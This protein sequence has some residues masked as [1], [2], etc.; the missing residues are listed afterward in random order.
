VNKCLFEAA[1][2]LVARGFAIYPAQAG[3]QKRLRGY[4]SD[5]LI[6]SAEHAERI[7]K[8]YPDANIGFVPGRS[9]MAVLDADMRNGGL[10]TH[11]NICSEIGEA[12]M[13]GAPVGLTP[14]GGFHLYFRYS[15]GPLP[16]NGLGPGIDI[17]SGNAGAIIPPSQRQDGSYRWVWDRFPNPWDPPP[18]PEALANRLKSVKTASSI[19]TRNPTIPSQMRNVSLFTAL[20][21]YAKAT[22]S[23]GF[24]LQAYAERLNSEFN[25]P[26]P[27]SEVRTI[28]NSVKSFNLASSWMPNYWLRCW[29]PHLTKR[30]LQVANSLYFVAE[31]ARKISITPAEKVLCDKSG[32]APPHF[33]S[34]RQRL[35][36]RG[37]IHVEHRG[38]NAACTTLLF[39]QGALC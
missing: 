8:R 1:I 20:S 3:T 18:F 23:D 33:Y 2:D 35:E 34:A 5:H 36:S 6:R 10:E 13:T 39:P 28:V 24:Q 25:P 16:K 19:L 27:K 14:G 7:W 37:A 4:T 22:S 30:E 15:G 12:W 38:L 26:L 17:I 9:G 21:D 29:T 11:E 31:E 32:L